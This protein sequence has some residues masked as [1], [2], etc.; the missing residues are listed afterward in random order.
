M[1]SL[2]QARSASGNLLARVR[3]INGVRHTLT[4]WKDETAMR[5]FIYRGAH[6]RAIGVFGAI[7]EGKT[8]G[9]ES[10]SVPGWPEVHR[11]WRARGKAYAD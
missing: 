10:T 7:A 1:P 2:L 8:F 6:K 9:F 4:V 11:F 5:D 3:T